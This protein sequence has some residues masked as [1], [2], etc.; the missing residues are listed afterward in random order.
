MLDQNDQTY[1]VIGRLFS[2]W[3]MQLGLGN[4]LALLPEAS[5]V[6]CLLNITVFLHIECN[7][8]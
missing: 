3:T 4:I 5:S 1:C 8:A 6:K 2:R 7:A